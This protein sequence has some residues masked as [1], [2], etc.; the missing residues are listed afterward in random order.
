[1]GAIMESLGLSPT[2]LRNSLEQGMHIVVANSYPQCFS[3]S[4][5]LGLPPYT[6]HSIITFLLESTSGLE[7]MDFTDSSAWKSILA[8]KGTLKVIVGN[9]LEVLS[10]GMYKSVFHQATPSPRLSRVSI[11]SFLSL[12]I[13]ETVEL[14]MK[15]VDEEHPQRYRATTFDEFF[16]HLSSNEERPYI[17]CLKI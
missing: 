6:D 16:N 15:L 10:N 13:G 12:R 9:H 1:M 14:A 11:A 17:D 2:Y 7:I 8:V 4:N 5:N 3:T